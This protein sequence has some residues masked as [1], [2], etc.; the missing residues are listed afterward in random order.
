MEIK[1]DTTTATVLVSET[2]MRLIDRIESMKENPNDADAD[3]LKVIYGA[4]SNTL[5]EL[6]EH[7]GNFHESQQSMIEQIT[8]LMV[9]FIPDLIEFGVLEID[10]DRVKVKGGSRVIH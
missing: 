1:L 7:M 2:A 4:L 9:T 3:A 6:M 8:E 5:T 10:E